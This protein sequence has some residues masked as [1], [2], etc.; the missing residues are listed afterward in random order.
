M[1]VLHV[2]T[3]CT[4]LNQQTQDVQTANVQVHLMVVYARTFTMQMY[5]IQLNFLSSIYIKLKEIECT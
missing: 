2:A 5:D 3:L 4:Q 1:A